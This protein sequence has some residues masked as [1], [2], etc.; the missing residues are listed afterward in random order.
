MAIFHFDSDIAEFLDVNAAVIHQNIKFWC[1]KNRA[2][3]RHFYDNHYWTYNSRKAFKELFPFLSDQSIKSALKRL[4][5][6]GYIMKGNYN[7]STYDR[8]LWYATIAENPIS[9]NQPMEWVVSTNGLGGI[10][11]PI[12]DIDIDNKPDISKSTRKKGKT[13]EEYL[14]SDRELKIE[15][16]DYATKHGH[17]DPETEWEM[18][19]NFWEANGE[20]KINW[21]ATWRNRVISS[22]KSGWYTEG[23]KH[24]GG[25]TERKSANQTAHSYGL[26]NSISLD[27][28]QS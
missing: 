27:D 8:T 25:K 23:N 24:S 7:K 13:I 19:V 26:R 2:N 3:G 17:P 15:F 28:M 22:K 11:Q 20:T 12:P 21:L 9:V 10:N 18:F 6:A 14:K 1:A 4:E 16:R 5:T